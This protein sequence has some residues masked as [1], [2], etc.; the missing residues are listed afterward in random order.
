MTLRTEPSERWVRG[1]AGDVLLVESRRPLLFWEDRF[2]V[3]NYA[4]PEVEV[5]LD[6]LTPSAAPQ[7]WHPFFGPHGPVTQVWDFDSDDVHL[8]AV[9]WRRDDPALDGY[10][11]LTW[12]PDTVRWTEEDEVVFGHPRDPHKRVDALQSSRHVVVSL[13]GTVLADTRRPVVLFETDLPT[14][15]Y[16]PR[17]DVRFDQLTAVEHVTVCPYKGVADGYW[18]HGDLANVAWSYSAP[19]PAVG[20]IAGHIAFYNEF[21]DIRVDDVPQPR[22]VSPFS[23]GRP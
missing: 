19:T 5:R 2:P 23:S 4:F 18:N 13:D 20:A 21:V 12:L 11:V 8:P 22:P 14:R 6:L 10:V 17:A 9:A 16:I 1:T 3:P 7:R 15:Y